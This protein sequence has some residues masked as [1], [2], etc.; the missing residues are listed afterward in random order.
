MSAVFAIA[1]FRIYVLI[2]FVAKQLQGV[3]NQDATPAAPQKTHDITQPSVLTLHKRSHHNKHVFLPR[4][5]G[6]SNSSAELHNTPR[7][8]QMA[9]DHFAY[10]SGVHRA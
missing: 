4:Q 7:L 2:S 3:L 5:S 6:K 10:D 1:L 8:H 9:T